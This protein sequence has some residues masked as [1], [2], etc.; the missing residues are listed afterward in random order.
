LEKTLNKLDN[1][2]KL[3]WQIQNTNEQW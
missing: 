3:K 2:D 1:K